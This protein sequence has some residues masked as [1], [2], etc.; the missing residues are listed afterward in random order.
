[1]QPIVEITDGTIKGTR[2]GRVNVFRGVRYGADTGGANRFRPPQPVEKWTGVRNAVAPGRSAPQF[3]KPECH[4]PFFSWYCAIE[5]PGEDCLSL[6]LFAPEPGNGQRPVMVWL[7][8][9]GWRDYSGTA[10]GFD[11]TALADAE[12]IVVVSLNHRLG[13]FGFVRLDGADTRFADSGNAG[14]LDI[15]AALEWIRDNIGVFGGDSDNVTLFGESG[16]ASK[17][18]ALLA[19]PRAKSLF[20]KAIM[21]SSGGGMTLAE[22]PEAE[23]VARSLAA[24]LGVDRLDPKAMQAL[25]MQVLLDATRKVS[26]SFRAMLDGRTFFTHP[27]DT[28]A[29]DLARDVPL[30]I[31]CTQTEATYFMRHDERNFR[32]GMEDVRRRLARFFDVDQVRTNHI[33]DTYC[34][35]YPAEQPY[36]ILCLA[37]SDYMFKR[38]GYRMAALQAASARAPVW[39]YH[40]EWITPIEG[41]R[42]MSPHTAELPFVFGTTKAARGCVGDGPD[43]VPMTRMMMATWA[44]F[45]RTGNPNNTTLP[46][47]LPYDGEARHMMVLDI[48]PH[49]ARDPGGVARAALDDLPF[50]GYGHSIPALVTG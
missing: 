35:A 44:A 26:G 38:N 2:I 24:S 29:P 22:P 19:A 5:P 11:A 50:Y 43:L 7:H 17:I 3:D 8:G 47:W 25:P 33:V 9:G 39:A 10:P 16:G 34:R 32:L 4:D 1:M 12:D 28:K 6:N 49:S 46:Q 45:A 40:F 37:A 30:M 18:A 14:I 41:G 42:M 21:S 13:V 27:F 36:V 23:G 20:H 48:V 15:A 31:G